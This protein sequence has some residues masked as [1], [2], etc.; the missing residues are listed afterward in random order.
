[1]TH[2]TQRNLRQDLT[3][4]APSAS[5]ITNDYGHAI[6]QAPTLIKGRW[7]DKVQQVRKPNGDEFIAQSEV[8]VDRDLEVGG[9]LALGDQTASSTPSSGA[10]EIQEFRKSPDLRNLGH[11]RRAYL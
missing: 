8:L 3:Y 4:W 6:P 2:F 1:M 11:E 7:E 5:G 10:W 9:H